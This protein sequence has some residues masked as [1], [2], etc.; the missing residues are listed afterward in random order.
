[1]TDQNFRDIPYRNCTPQHTADTREIHYALK[2]VFD[3]MLDKGYSPEAIVTEMCC[4][5]TTLYTTFNIRT[6]MAQRKK[7]KEARE[8]L[9]QE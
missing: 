1:M 3:V 6:G 2:G 5:A 9:E 7:D 8:S 4:S